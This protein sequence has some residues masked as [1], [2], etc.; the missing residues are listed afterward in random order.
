MA[1]DESGTIID[2]FDGQQ[3]LE[4]RIFRHVLDAFIEDP[5]R[6]LRVARFAARYAYL[7]FH[8]ADE[9]LSLMRN[10][11]QSGEL[12]ALTPERVWQETSKA[13]DE[14]SPQVYFEVLRQ[15]DALS[16][17]MPE[18]NKLWGV[19]NPEKW[20][21]EIDTGIH[22]MMVLAQAA[23]LS[24]DNSV[25]FAALTHDLG[26]GLTKPEHWPH[27]HGHEKSGLVPLKSLCNRLKVPNEHKQLAMLVCEY[28]THCHRALELNPKTVVKL[29]DSL[30]AW[31]KPQRFH[32]FLTC[33]KADMRGRTGFE[34]APYLQVTFLEEMLVSANKVD[35]KEIVAAGFKGAGIREEV[36]KRRIE[37]V[38]LSKKLWLANHLPA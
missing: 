2:F 27:H 6:V 17:V 16:A 21:P 15:C 10:I 24:S 26:K 23:K 5:L 22:T 13:L 38:T 9:T 25:R 7:G 30:D 12:D 29:F 3:D 4:N 8:V 34:D 35:I 11:A 36:G 37:A 19:P 18:L 14:R 31:R 1:Q 28:H 32:Q 33:C 20:H